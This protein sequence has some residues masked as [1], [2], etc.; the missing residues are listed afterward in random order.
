MAKYR[1]IVLHRWKRFIEMMQQPFPFLILRRLPKA[2]RMI[3]KGLPVDQKDV[4]VR[5]FEAAQQLM[6]DVAQHRRDDALRF[7]EGAFEIR[8]FARADVEY[9]H[10]EDHGESPFAD[11]ER[12]YPLTAPIRWVA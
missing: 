7:R 6:Q 11:T 3:F 1:L 5:R 2:L 10:F 12:P 8:A 9:R 4:A